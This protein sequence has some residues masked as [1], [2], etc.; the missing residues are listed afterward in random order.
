MR[1]FK[2]YIHEKIKRGEIK[3]PE[4]F[5]AQSSTIV[6]RIDYLKEQRENREI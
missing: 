6:P 4:T 3:R 5:Q 1:L 2:Q